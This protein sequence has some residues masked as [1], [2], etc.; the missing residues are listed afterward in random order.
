LP[1]KERHATSLHH[2]DGDQE[3]FSRTLTL[4]KTFSLFTGRKVF[5][6]TDTKL[7]YSRGVAK[8]FWEKA[9]EK[10]ERNEQGRALR[11]ILQMLN[12]AGIS[13]QEMAAEKIT[14]LSPTRWKSL[15]GFTRPQQNLAWV[16]DL[17]ADMPADAPPVKGMETDA[18]AMYADALE[19]GLPQDNIL[20]LVAEAVDKRK[21]LFK[22]IRKHGVIFD[23]A[24]DPGSSAGAKR[25]QD[26]ILR[27]LLH[28]TVKKYGKEI[29][30][31]CIAVFL[32]RVGFHPVAAV[33]EAEKLSFYVGDRKVITRKDVDAIIGRTREEA[34]FE[35]NEAV[36]AGKLEDGLR[37][38]DH[39][40]SSGVH[41]LAVLA[42]LRKHIK[43]ML[44]VRS[45]QEISPPSYDKSLTFKKFQTSYL[46]KIKEGREEWTSLLWKSHPYALYMLFRQANQFRCQT[47][48]G[49]MQEL[50]TAEYRMK[51]SSVDGR[52]IMDSLL[53]NLMRPEPPE[54][55]AP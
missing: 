25:D 34:L 29:E 38:L 31:E 17:L 1:D 54:R 10:N 36:T 35:L 39:L 23:L 42:T 11:Y 53:F 37:I 9:C 6:V 21:R 47:L 5:L 19:A 8:S 7:F 40:Q 45:L 26:K 51:G 55:H 50:L 28:T 16:Q 15:F 52:L 4:L 13:P 14:S 27:E 33:M 18:A 46:P 22:Y 48:Q 2:I 32:E 30:P 20:I 41:G 44:L 3:D 12:L 49:W 24:V 43:K